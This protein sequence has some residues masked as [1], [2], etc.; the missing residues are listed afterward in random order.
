MKI[1]AR[2]SKLEVTDAIRDYINK[3][4]A[5]LDK[6]F[7]NP[8][9]FT[10]N[11]LIK[12]IG[13][14][15]T[16]EVTI[17]IRKVILRAEE[18]SEDLYKSIDLVSEKL[19]RQIRKNK[20]RILNKKGQE[21]IFM[22]MSSD[23]EKIEEEVGVIKKRKQVDMKPMSEEEAILQLNLIGHDFFLFEDMDTNRPTVV[24]RRKDG[25]YGVIEM[26]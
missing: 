6:Y 1:N 17:P 21:P 24:Y 8:D 2:G 3:K 20:T 12:T 25:N 23:D 14:S 26:K 18:S 10:A 9:E 4:V 22:F 5:K 15:Q 19:E 16:V 7:E 13:N 11:I